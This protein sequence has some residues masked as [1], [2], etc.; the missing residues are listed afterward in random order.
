MIRTIIFKIVLGIYFTLWSPLLLIGLVS[1]KL[2]RKLVFADA[3]LIPMVFDVSSVR[4]I[5]GGAGTNRGTGG[6]VTK[7]NAAK[8][9]M[10]KGTDMVI[11]NGSNPSVLYDI[12]DGEK[13][14]TKF[15]AK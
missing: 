14:G 10:S 3:E 1:K 9:C 11:A 4:G 12:V 13:I 15:I 8:L 2:S 5:A 6:M 7:L